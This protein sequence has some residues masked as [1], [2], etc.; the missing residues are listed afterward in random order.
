MSPSPLDCDT[1]LASLV[2]AAQSGDDVA[3]AQLVERFDPML[4]TVAR[5]YRMRPADVDDAVQATWIRLYEHI[6]SVR[7]ADA[8][9]GWLATTVRRQALRLLQRHVREHLVDDA[10]PAA[11]EDWCEGPEAHA[12]ATERRVVLTRALASLPDRQRRL[13]TLIASDPDTAYD[14]IS[15]SLGIPR[16]SI[17]P[18]RARGLACLERHPELRR[19]AAAS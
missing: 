6:D 15:A 11:C 10:W 1:P 2:R 5:S 3:W 14:Q 17:G 9:G 4:R 13:M 8:I 7:D 16:G 18:L 12:L 19:L